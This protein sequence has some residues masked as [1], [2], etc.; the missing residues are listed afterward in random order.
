MDMEQAR[1][2]TLD[3]Q[4]WKEE[5]SGKRQFTEQQFLTSTKPV[6]NAAGSR[7]ADR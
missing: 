1:L 7:C 6:A 5:K 3:F 2:M 4:R